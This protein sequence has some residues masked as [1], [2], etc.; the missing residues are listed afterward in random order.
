MRDEVP[1]GCARI[2]LI[3]GVLWAVGAIIGV[4]LC[5]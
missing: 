1:E 5:A 2:V 3:V 4:Y